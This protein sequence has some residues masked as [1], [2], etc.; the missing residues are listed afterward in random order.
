MMRHIKRWFAIRSY[1]TRLSADLERRFDLRSSYTVEQVTQAVERGGYTP[2]FIAYAHATFCSRQGFDAHYQELGVACTY[3][4]LR[5]VV[6]RR[7]FRGSMGFD[8]AIVIRTFRRQ[9]Y[10]EEASFDES[11]GGD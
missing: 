10:A 9:R 7:Y 6:A 2:V 3:D 11:G 5:A 4:G 8:A 1:V